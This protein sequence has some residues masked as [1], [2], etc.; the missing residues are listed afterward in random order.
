MIDAVVTW[1][2]GNESSHI[3]KKRK[4]MTGQDNAINNTTIPAGVDDTRFVSNNE[5][6]YCIK[7]I[8]KFAPWVRTIFLVT[9]KQ[10]PKF[11]DRTLRNQLGVTLIDH[12]VIFRGFEYNLPTF[13]SLSIETLLYRIPG[14]TSKFLYF[15]DDFILTALTRED[16]FF[17]GD[18]VVLRGQWCKLQDYGRLRLFISKLL[19]KILKKYFGIN[20]AMSVLQQMRGAQLVE[21][22]KKFFKVGHTP[23]P[24]TTQT[25]GTFFS[26]HPNIQISNIAFRFRSLKQFA[27]TSLANH[28][29]I[30]KFKAVFKTQ[31]DAEMICFNRD[32]K[33]G[34][35]K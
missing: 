1:V 2:D 22:K 23:Y 9:D 28:L 10:C 29:E 26:E 30:K 31:D 35:K 33:K 24:I 7:S 21:F 12:E 32:S 19:N 14:I 4:F 6:E 11:L 13:N 17:M 20:R 3:M 27:T 5:I 34:Y 25:L 18:K 15:N 16:D 8:R